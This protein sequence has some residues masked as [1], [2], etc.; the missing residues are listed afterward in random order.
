MELTKER[1][2]AIKEITKVCD[3]VFVVGHYLEIGQRSAAWLTPAGIDDL[4]KQAKKDEQE[5][6]SKGFIYLVTPDF[7]KRILTGC[8]ILAKY[9]SNIRNAVIKKYI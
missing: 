6:R 2:A 9:P 3:P 4:T 7:Q 5:S 8:A 1:D